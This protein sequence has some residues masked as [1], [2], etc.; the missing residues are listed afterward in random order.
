MSRTFRQ[1][2]NAV[3]C[4]A[5]GLIRDQARGFRQVLKERRRQAV[6]NIKAHTAGAVGERSR[7][8]WK[9][10]KSSTADAVEGAA[11]ASS[12]A[13]ASLSSGTREMAGRAA[14]NTER[15]WQSLKPN[16]GGGDPDPRP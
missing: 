5:G 8:I 1:C 2:V 13:A 4:S 14:A 9:S 12:A 3:C 16:V 7:D 10:V 6:Q 15:I 11:Q